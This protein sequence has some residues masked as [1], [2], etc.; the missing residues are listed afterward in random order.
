ML[1]GDT[2]LTTERRNSELPEPDAEKQINGTDA[3]PAVK[4]RGRGRPRN[5]EI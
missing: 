4:K 1:L 5:E 3:D 2:I